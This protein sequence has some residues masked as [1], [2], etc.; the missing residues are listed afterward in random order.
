LLRRNVLLS[1]PRI[2]QAKARGLEVKVAIDGGAASGKWARE[3][4]AIYPEA[5]VVCIEPRDAVQAELQKLA[6]EL[7]GINLVKT[8]LGAREG[9][10]EFN[11]YEDMGSMLPTSTGEHFG[12]VVKERVATLDRVIDEIALGAPPDMIKLDLQGAELQA[13]DGAT[14]SLERAQA[15]IL[16]VSFIQLQ[17]DGPLFA[18]VI[19]YMQQLG[20]R[21]YDVRALAQR[22]LDGALAQG[23]VMFLREGHPLLASG[24][25][26]EEAIWT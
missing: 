3:L 12:T 21:C 10:A 25:W 20:F 8:R 24:K 22:P 16:E 14:R 9:T 26:S 7:P 18:D 4:K 1:R 5:Q 23:D 6:A 2:A 15:V 17:K 19:C 11:V 13:L